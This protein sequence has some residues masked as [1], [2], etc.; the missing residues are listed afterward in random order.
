MAVEKARRTRKSRAGCRNCK[1]RKVKVGEMTI[2]TSFP[3]THVPE[4]LWNEK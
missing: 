1:L 4:E 3:C 2:L